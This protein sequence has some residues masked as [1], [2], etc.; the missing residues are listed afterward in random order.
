MRQD[1]SEQKEMGRTSRS[2]QL[3]SLRCKCAQGALLADL[4]CCNIAESV[5]VSLSERRRQLGLAT[6]LV[7]M[8][9]STREASGP[10]AVQEGYR[11]SLEC[12]CRRSHGC[13][14]AVERSSRHGFCEHHRRME[15]ALAS[16]QLAD[17][18]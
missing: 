7:L 11:Q 1:S 14:C 16:Q 5:R 4:S 10:A 6:M 12:F 3:A 18:Q 9:R 15:C 13:A 17:D 2:V 8:Q